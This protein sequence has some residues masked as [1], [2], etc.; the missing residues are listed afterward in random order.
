MMSTSEILAVLRK[1][2]WLLAFC[3]LVPLV[4]FRVYGFDRDYRYY[5]EFFEQLVA[6]PNF[7]TR[8][9]LGFVWLTKLVIFLA[10]DDFL[11]FLLVCAATSLYL[12]FWIISRGPA[13]F[14]CLLLYVLILLPLHEMTQIRISIAIGL[15]MLGVFLAARESAAGGLSIK[16]LLLLL[17]GAFF[18]SSILI[19]L[20][21]FYIKF[22]VRSDRMIIPAVFLTTI[23]FCMGFGLHL[24]ALL[25]PL[26]SAYFENGLEGQVNLFSSRS[27]AF[28]LVVML[29]LICY[30]RLDSF[31][32]ILLWISFFGLSNYF[33]LAW[34]PVFAHRFMEI[35][36]FPL[37]LM[38]CRLPH[39][40]RALAFA[41]LLGLGIY[42]NYHMI[43][44]DPLFADDFD[45]WDFA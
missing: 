45:S 6:E 22:F 24:T 29:G 42:V 32:R 15:A 35:S 20:P 7:D 30:R 38:A 31:T 3:L 12:K 2:F 36:M 39:G 10:G 26:I 16:A 37:L 27:I 19:L 17:I 40:F 5:L 14:F 8:F 34:A 25:N 21:F 41:V 4:G 11:I 13:G 33:F 9:E 44:V 18:Q 1:A 43:Y 28:I 23:S